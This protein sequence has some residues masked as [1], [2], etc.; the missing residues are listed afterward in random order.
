[1]TQ[2][3]QVGRFPLHIPS[4]PRVL[5]TPGPAPRLLHCFL[6]MK[7]SFFKVTISLVLW[8]FFFLS[9]KRVPCCT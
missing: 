7:T 3:L 5:P 9:R 1:V 6:Q 8:A 2:E 4:A